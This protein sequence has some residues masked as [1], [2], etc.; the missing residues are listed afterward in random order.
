M[1][2]APDLMALWA[3]GVAA[4]EGERCVAQSLADAPIT[5]PDRILAVGKAAGA[6][7]SAALG[8]FPGTPALVVTKHDHPGANGAEL[9]EAGHPVPDAHSLRA[10]AA[11]VDALNSC[12]AGSHLLVLVSG[13]ASALA[14]ALPEGMGL[15][16]L[17]AE[18]QRLL[19]SGADIH[20]MNKRRRE[21]SLIKGGRLFDGFLGA[22]VTTLAISD[23]EG[24]ALGVIGSGIGAAPETAG[25][26]TD[27]RIVASNAIAR[28]AIVDAAGG[29]L[30]ANEECLYD[31]VTALAPALG[32]KLRDGPSGLYL[33]GGEPTVALPEN[34]GKG[35]RNMA[36]GLELAREIAG[37]GIELLVA[38]TDGTDG[39]TDA[40]GAYVNGQ[41]WGEGAQDAL[42]RAD[43]YTWL[44]TRDGLF[45][46]GPT[47][48]NVMD[49]ALAWKP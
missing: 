36:L 11:L 17:A 8:A 5:R 33:F 40:A 38:G 13:G 4:V 20:A 18:T 34:P 26:A 3:A 1:A 43:A 22:R 12:P 10:G 41:T 14:E 7:A 9:I 42:V 47:G 45:V 39:P 44:N 49:L 31:D 27:L 15:E 24:D 48:T 2:Q 19:A 23:V 25:F 37:T 30:V 21:I 32:K 16:D 35:G 29:G 6:M 46:T 28:A